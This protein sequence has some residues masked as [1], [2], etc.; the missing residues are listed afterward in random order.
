MFMSLWFKNYTLSIIAVHDDEK[1]N[2]EPAPQWWTHP[3]H[4][5]DET[6]N[7]IITRTRTNQLASARPK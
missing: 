2:P 6:T 1:K 7:P 5:D 3:L 4:G